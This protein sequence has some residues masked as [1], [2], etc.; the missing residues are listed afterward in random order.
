MSKPD[1]ITYIPR[2]VFDAARRLEAACERIGCP[3]A[4]AVA[5]Y[6]SESRTTLAARVLWHQ[7]WCFLMEEDCIPPDFDIVF[8]VVDDPAFDCIFSTTPDGLH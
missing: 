1:A 6:R 8:V 4:I 5:E 3:S 7:V 2:R